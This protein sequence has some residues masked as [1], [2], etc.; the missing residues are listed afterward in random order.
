MVHEKVAHQWQMLFQAWDDAGLLD[1]I[2]MFSGP[3]AVRYMRGVTHDGKLSSLSNHSWGTAIDL[4]VP[5]NPLKAKPA[6]MGW[7]GCVM[8]LVPIAHQFG[9]YWG[10]HFGRL[11]GMHFEVAQVI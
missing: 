3:L 1:R 8:E 9:F 4:N 10:G 11:D 5:W 2:L 7:Q 6:R